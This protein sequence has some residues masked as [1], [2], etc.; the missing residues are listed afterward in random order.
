MADA[1]ESSPEGSPLKKSRTTQDPSEFVQS[2]LDFAARRI[3][4]IARAQDEL[5]RG[6]EEQEV[7][8]ARKDAEIR[9]LKA[10]RASDAAY[11]RD[12]LQRKGLY[13]YGKVQKQ[14][15]GSESPS[16]NRETRKV[17][18]ES[19]LSQI[20]GFTNHGYCTQQITTRQNT[21]SSTALN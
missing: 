19:A 17:A 18:P 7:S 15:E 6:F 4:S 16:V 13:R 11:L 20:L 8:M 10:Q 12:Y 9:Q 2:L 3:K 21:I 14:P 1:D 5:R